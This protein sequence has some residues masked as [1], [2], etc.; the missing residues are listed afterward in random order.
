[1]FF[2]HINAT[3]MFP[4]HCSR[5]LQLQ[6]ARVCLA[7]HTS[8]F[9]RSVEANSRFALDQKRN[10]YWPPPPE[11]RSRSIK[12][13]SGKRAFVFIAKN[14]Q[15]GTPTPVLCFVDSQGQRL[16]WMDQ[17]EVG[18]FEKIIPRLQSY[19]DLY[20]QKADVER[21]RQVEMAE[22]QVK[23]ASITAD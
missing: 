10:V 13:P 7:Q 14:D 19:M 16:M 18:E 9:V 22:Q 3:T 4:S 21:L 11:A 1:M 6:S 15:D 23:N 8:T 2:R 17:E 12:L 20:E 5:F